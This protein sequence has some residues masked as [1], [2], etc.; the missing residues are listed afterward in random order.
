MDF[1]VFV[2][3][4]AFEL[5]DVNVGL[6]CAQLLRGCMFWHVKLLQGAVFTFELPDK[7]TKASHREVAGLK[8][9]L[10]IGALVGCALSFGWTWV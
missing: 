3:S 8:E 2:A 6:R 5:R 7:S 10:R 1:A 9:A 4:A